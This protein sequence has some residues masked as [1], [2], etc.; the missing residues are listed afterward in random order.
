MKRKRLGALRKNKPK[1]LKLPRMEGGRG[2]KR[3]NFRRALLPKFYVFIPSVP[4]DPGSSLRL[5][6]A[7]KKST[8]ELRVVGS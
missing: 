3:A 8:C 7:Y 4:P 2:G 6:T 1:V 5:R